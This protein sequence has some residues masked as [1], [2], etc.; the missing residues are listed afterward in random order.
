MISVFV[1]FG[2]ES[3]VEMARLRTGNNDG[4]H[5]EE[6]KRKDVGGGAEK[7]YR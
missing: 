5:M 3:V 2:S 7:R 6:Q 4:N 1:V